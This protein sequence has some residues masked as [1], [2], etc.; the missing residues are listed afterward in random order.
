MEKQI[1]LT[2]LNFFT[3]VD[4]LLSSGMS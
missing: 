4:N 3:I 2:L 1:T